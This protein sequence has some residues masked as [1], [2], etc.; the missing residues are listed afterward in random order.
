MG[1]RQSGGSDVIVSSSDTDSDVIGFSF[2]RRAS[3]VIA[4]P[5]IALPWCGE[6]AQKTDGRTSTAFPADSDV[7]AFGFDYRACD[8]IEGGEGSGGSC[9][10]AAKRAP[11]VEIVRRNTDTC[12]YVLR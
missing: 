5:V 2:D 7:I 8:V 10:P 6:R 3:D 11:T 12:F 4:L 1:R 9:Q